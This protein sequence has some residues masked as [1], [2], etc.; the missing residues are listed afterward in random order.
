MK[1]VIVIG[2]TGTLGKAVCAALAEKHEVV[3]VGKSGGDLQ[4]DITSEQSIATLFEKVGAFDALVLAAGDVAFAGLEDMTSEQWAVGLQSKMMGQINA[5]RHAVKHLNDAG[6]ITLVSGV[7]TDEPIAWGAAA[8]TVN[9]AINHFVK[10]AATELPR[11]IRIN[12]VSPTMLTESKPVYGDFF[13]GFA[14]VP[15]EKVA[16]AY[17]KSVMG[18]QTGRVFEIYE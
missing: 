15:A 3:A 5:T 18:V 10:A 2:A 8:S 12:V 17:V 13:P 1:K 11:G 6:S 14:D 7:L 16:K 9:G 4:V